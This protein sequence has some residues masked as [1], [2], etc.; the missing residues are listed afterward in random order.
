MWSL[1]FSPTLFSSTSC[2]RLSYIKHTHLYS[3]LL[4]VYFPTL[5]M[6]DLPQINMLERCFLPH[7]AFKM[8]EHRMDGVCVCGGVNTSV[9][10]PQ[11]SQP[12]MM[13]RCALNDRF[14][15]CPPSDSSPWSTEGHEYST[16]CP[17]FTMQQRS[18]CALCMWTH[19]H[20]SVT[21]PASV[22]DG[23][24]QSS[25]PLLASLTYTFI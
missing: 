12:S 5:C 24:G 21:V 4:S 1:W 8:K 16:K 14:F 20:L 15:P 23:K 2:E 6:S 18:M 3:D 13:P 10:R 19:S 9:Y 25:E 17:L 7:S 11:D 22:W